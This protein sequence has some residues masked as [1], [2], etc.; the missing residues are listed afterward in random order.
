MG[1]LRALRL[2]SLVALH[3]LP[4]AGSRAQSRPGIS[5]PQSKSRP[6]VRLPQL[7]CTSS[8]L[9]APPTQTVS[10]QADAMPE[11]CFPYVSDS[12]KSY[13]FVKRMP[14]PAAGGGPVAIG[15]WLQCLV[16][17]PAEVPAGRV[18]GRMF[19]NFT[20]GRHGEVYGATVVKALS[21]ACDAA[22]LAAVTRLPRLVPGYLNGKAVAVNLTLRVTFYGSHWVYYPAEVALAARF[23]A[24]GVAAYVRR[25]RRV[26]APKQERKSPRVFV[27]FVVGADGRV[28]EPRVQQSV[29]ARSD[30]EALRLVRAMPRW[31]PARTYQGQAVAVR[32]QLV[33]VVPG[34]PALPRPNN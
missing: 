34:P 12:V 33:L 17:I 22:A 23:P 10:S 24:P 5:G 15:R 20:V 3:L 2:V 29:S 28:R 18:E 32:E 8:Y 4:V 11:E 9:V 6:V 30:Q 1:R 26:P 14:Q 21:P 27:D 25:N 31:Q 13:T 7:P 19:V 16:T